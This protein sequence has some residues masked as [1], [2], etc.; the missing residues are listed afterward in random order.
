MNMRGEYK[1]HYVVI[2]VMKR[3]LSFPHAA[4]ISWRDERKFTEKKRVKFTTL[5]GD[6]EAQ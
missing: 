4:S 1:K 2:W 5:V 3:I 6:E